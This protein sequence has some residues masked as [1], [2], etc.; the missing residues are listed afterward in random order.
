MAIFASLLPLLR[1]LKPG[2]WLLGAVLLTAI[3]LAAG[4]FAP[5]LSGCRALAVSLIE[6]LL[7]VALPDAACSSATPRCCG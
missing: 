1:V 5:P 4:Y 7:W 2:A 6:V 3:V